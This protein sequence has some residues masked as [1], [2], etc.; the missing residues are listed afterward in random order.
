VQE[1]YGLSEASPVVTVNPPD[2]IKAGSIGPAIPNVLTRVR[3]KE[4][5]EVKTGVVGELCVQGPNVMLGYLNNPEATAQT[6]RGGWLHT[7]DMAYKDEEG[8]IFLVDRLKDMIIAA[9]ENVYPREIEEILYQHPAVKEVAVIGVPD[10][11]RGQ[12]VAAY[13]VLKPGKTATKPELRKFL[14]GKLAN[15]K[16]PKYFMFLEQMPKTQ[17]GKILK[18]AL[19]ERSIA[20]LIGPIGK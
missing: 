19:R 16:L 11:L 9:G 8:Y 12:A 3:N 7:G 15:Y 18:K 5:Q 10:K 17:T 2:K 1:G 6:L 13:V 20:D 4:D 14:R